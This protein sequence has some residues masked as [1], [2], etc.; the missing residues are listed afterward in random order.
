MDKPIGD[1][2]DALAK[3][4]EY[5]KKK[6]KPPHISV[7]IT[8]REI[9][10]LKHQ[11]KSKKREIEAIQVRLDKANVWMS[12]EENQKH[13]KYAAYLA[14]AERL[15]DKQRLIR[16]EIVELVGTIKTKEKAIESELAMREREWFARIPV[17]YQPSRSVEEMTPGQINDALL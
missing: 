11:I 5:R 4:N 16:S 1:L 8:K 14:E 13:D 3:A 9:E 15:E 6:G 2:L 17:Q 12:V 10:D 7:T